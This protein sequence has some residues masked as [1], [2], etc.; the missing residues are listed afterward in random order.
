MENKQKNP[1]EEENKKD[2][3]SANP[4]NKTPENKE[5]ADKEHPKKHSSAASIDSIITGATDAVHSRHASSNLGNTG[6]NISYEGATAPGGSGSVGTG[7]SSGQDATG[8]TINTEGE[9]DFVR[10]HKHKDEDDTD[11]ENEKEKDEDTLGN[12]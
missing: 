8:T 5:Q 3:E 1:Q 12:P 4:E 2:Q 11:E 10:D 6:T 9:N 7:Y